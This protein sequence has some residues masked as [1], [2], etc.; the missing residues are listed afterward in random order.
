MGAS[1]ARLSGLEGLS[2]SILVGIVPL[3]ALDTLGSKEAV[4]YVYLTGAVLTF[5]ITINIGTL[6]RLLH[7]RRVVVLGGLFLIIAA[8]LLHTEAAAL[9]A[10]GIGMRSA[11]ASI[12]S[13]CIS[14]Y[15]MDHIGRRELTRNESIRLAFTGA[16]W[17]VGPAL[18]V[19]L[20]EAVS[21]DLAFGLSALVALAMILY[22]RHLRLGTDHVLSAAL[23]RPPNPLRALKRY[24]DQPRLRIAY[25]I[26]LSRSC[27]WVAL[28]VYGPIYVVEAGLPTWV[29]GALLSGVSGLLLFSP[30]V[31]ALADRFGTRQVIIG[32]LAITGLSTIA[33]GLLQTPTPIGI[34]FWITGAFG[35]A[36]LDVLGNIPFMRTVKPRE[37]VEMTTIFSTWREGSELVTPALVAVVLL[38]APFWVFYFVLGLMH[39]A[40][41][42]SASFLPKR[43]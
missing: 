35:G 25:G 14:L 9:F 31:R 29:A 27:Y 10:V 8:A 26:T 28:F 23:S 32:G 39:L 3:I 43:L 1:L 30:A 22:F 40:S 13:V 19:W 12:F 21:P 33:L 7:R 41:A 11:A 24:L 15:I 16:A 20:Y 17:L 5:F 38:I 34:V 2:R 36:A 37:R 6:E 4:S 18:G 42:S